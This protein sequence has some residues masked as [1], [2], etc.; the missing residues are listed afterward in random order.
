MTTELLPAN[1]QIDL[2]NR[3]DAHANTEK[4]ALKLMFARAVIE[5]KTVITRE[6]SYSVGRNLVTEGA[7]DE[8]LEFIA[9][10]GVAEAYRYINDEGEPTFH[11]FVSND[12]FIEIGHSYDKI[13]KIRGVMYSVHSFDETLAKSLVTKMNGLFPENPHVTK[14]I[15]YTLVMT[16]NGP[17]IRALGVVGSNL[18]ETNYSPDTVRAFFHIAKDIASSDPCGRMS[19]FS[20]SPGTGKT[21]LV[22]SLT[23]AVQ[24]RF[25]MVSTST[26][27]ALS[28]PELVNVLISERDGE[29]WPIVLVIEDADECLTSR[30]ADNMASLS[31]LLNL[32]DGMLGS[33]LNLYIVATTNA[34]TTELDEAVCRPGRLCRH[35]HVDALDYEQALI[36][37]GALTKDPD[38][39]PPSQRSHKLA[40]LYQ[41]TRTDY[42][43]KEEAKKK[44]VGFGAR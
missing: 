10:L 35:V 31:A 41:M 38:A 42:E 15:I 27:R 44:V 21:H 14:D 37:W 16:S 28:G 20:G 39:V 5:R 40:E 24:A 2:L 1:W 26:L 34:M 22:R 12:T 32:S 13:G 4:W 43:R 8:A 30:G 23:H 29:D 9:N 11:S 3:A 18:V 36:C 19:I 17:E 6:E 33:C 7:Y 25:I